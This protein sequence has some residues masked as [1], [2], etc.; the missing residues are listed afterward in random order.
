ML[1][2]QRLGEQIRSNCSL[3]EFMEFHLESQEAVSSNISTFVLVYTINR[4]PEQMWRAL[5]HTLPRCICG[6]TD[7]I[8]ERENIRG[9]PKENSGEVFTASFLFGAGRCLESQVSRSQ[10][11]EAIKNE[12]L[13]LL[14]RLR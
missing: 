14:L 13:V 4:L 11:N 10:M 3:V 9:N 12:P 1:S 5:V 6:S 2:L 7:G 8:S